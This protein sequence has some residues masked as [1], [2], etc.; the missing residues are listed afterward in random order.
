MTV[1]AVFLGPDCALEA[2]GS[3]VELTRVPSVWRLC[4]D[5][6]VDPHQAVPRV[7]DQ[8]GGSTGTVYEVE[9]ACPAHTTPMEY[10]GVYLESD[11]EAVSQLLRLGPVV[12][13]ARGRDAYLDVLSGLPCTA[14]VWRETEVGASRA[15][16]D[17]AVPAATEAGGDFRLE[18]AQE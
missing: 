1:T 13:C 2:D 12:L 5:F 3:R 6:G 10:G 15:E 18:V 4:R 14:M 8:A 7:L 16:A 17:P 11:R 9:G